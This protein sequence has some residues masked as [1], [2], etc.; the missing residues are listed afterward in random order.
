MRILV[1][2]RKF[3][4][5]VGGVERMSTTLMNEMVR[6]GHDVSLF[7]W[8]EKEDAQSFYD[9]EPSIQWFK[10]AMGNPAQKAGFVLRL[11][12][13]LRVRKILKSIRP[14][15]VV[16]FQEGAYVTLKL[17]SLGMGI[18]MVCAIRNSP[19]RDPS[20]PISPPFWVICASFILAASVTV[21][22]ERYATAFPKFLRSKIKTIHNPVLAASSIADVGGKEGMKMVLS[23]G[24][25]SPEKNHAV[26]IDAFAMIADAFPDWK[27]VIVGRGAEESRLKEKIALLPK[28]VS[29]RIELAG[30]SDD[31]PSWLRQAHIFC[32]PSWWEGFPNS[33]AEAMAHGL[34][35]VGFSQCDGVRDLIRDGVTGFL[36]DGLKDPQ[37]LAEKLSVL[38]ADSSLRQDMGR[39]ALEESR[40]FEPKTIFDEWEILLKEA[41]R[42]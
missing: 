27:L 15:V 10:M 4:G 8:D 21:Q 25:L 13:A 3:D 19:F 40:R 34:P 32:F 42:T 37:S 31:V 29:G 1:A 33:L 7:T 35:S 38:M 11:Q 18:P 2:C 9:M 41:L 36:A 39:A 26:L 16:G 6:R 5:V 30:V 17:Y 14:D 23:T 20:V 22:F 28:S 12:R 24:R